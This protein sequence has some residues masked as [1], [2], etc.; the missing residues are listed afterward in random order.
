MNKINIQPT[1]CNICGWTVE[2]TDSKKVYGKSFGMIYLCTQCTARVSV[3]KGT[4]NAMWI[5]ADSELRDLKKMC[6]SLFDTQWRTWLRS[7][8]AAYKLLAKGMWIP[9]KHC[10]I[11]RFDTQLCN[12]AIDTLQK[13]YK[14]IL[15]EHYKNILTD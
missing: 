14:K 9:H 3:H 5:L 8:K 13:D 4:K 12:K 2:Y 10:H 15:Q 6:H 7:R 1:E 11:G